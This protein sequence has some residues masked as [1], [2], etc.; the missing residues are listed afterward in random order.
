MPSNVAVDQLA[1]RL[2]RTGLKVIRLTAKSREHMNSNVQHLTL[3]ER[4]RTDTKNEELLKLMQLK[5]EL[6]ELSAADE[7]EVFEAFEEC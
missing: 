2:E 7:K 3:H 1:E 6:G 5:D 4:V